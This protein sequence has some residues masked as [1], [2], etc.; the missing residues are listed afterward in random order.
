MEPSGQRATVGRRGHPKFL[1]HDLSYRIYRDKMMAMDVRTPLRATQ[2]EVIFL[3]F[4][5]HCC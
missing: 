5:D 1:K 4:D 3:V 2:G